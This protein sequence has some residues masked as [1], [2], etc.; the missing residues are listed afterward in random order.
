M[1]RQRGR[2]DD[3]KGGTV[4]GRGAATKLDFGTGS[5]MLSSSYTAGAAAARQGGAATS[6]SYG[7]GTTNGRRL[8]A[9]HASRSRSAA[10]NA[11]HAADEQSGF[12]DTTTAGP[13]ATGAL[14]VNGV[15]APAQACARAR[16]PAVKY[17]G[18]IYM[19]GG[20]GIPDRFNG[21]RLRSDVCFVDTQTCVWHRVVCTGTAFPPPRMHH[22]AGVKDGKLVVHGGISASGEVLN[23]MWALSLRAD[24]H[25]WKRVALYCHADTEPPPL[26]SH[27]AAVTAQVMYFHGGRSS[28]PSHTIY[29]FAFQTQAWDAIESANIGPLL[30]DHCVEVVDGVLYAFGGFTYHQGRHD[31]VNNQLFAYSFE[32]GVWRTISFR[33]RG[34]EN[35]LHDFLTAPLLVR[36]VRQT[37]QLWFAGSSRVYFAALPAG[38]ATCVVFHL[39]SKPSGVPEKRLHSVA[40]AV[41]R[42][43]WLMFGE[44]TGEDPSL[45][46]SSPTAVRRLLAE[47]HATS[48]VCFADVNVYTI[49]ASSWAPAPD[50]AAALN[51]TTAG[52]VAGGDAPALHSSS[53]AR[54]LSPPR[55]RR[56]PQSS[57]RTQVS[58]LARLLK[59]KHD[60]DK[61][62]D[63][64][65]HT[66]I[67]P[68]DIREYNELLGTA[69]DKY[70]A[71]THR[72][73]KEGRKR[74]DIRRARNI[75]SSKAS[76][77]SRGYVLPEEE[78]SPRPSLVAEGV[79]GRAAR[80]AGA[81]KPAA[82]VQAYAR[83]AV[84]AAVVLALRRR[85]HTQ[86]HQAE[87]HQAARKIQAAHRGRTVRKHVKTRR[88]QQAA[89]GHLERHRAATKIQARYRGD[90]ARGQTARLL[91]EARREQEYQRRKRQAAIQIQRVQRG[92]MARAR[93]PSVR[94]P[95]AAPPATMDAVLRV[96]LFGLYR[97]DELVASLLFLARAGK[98]T[99]PPAAPGDG[100]ARARAAA[101][102]QTGVRR[103]RRRAAE[104]FFYWGSTRAV[105]A[106]RLR[107]EAAALRIQRAGRGGGGRADARELEL[108]RQNEAAAAIQRRFRVHGARRVAGARAGGDKARKAAA[109]AA[110]QAAARAKLA[111]LARRRRRGAVRIQ[112]AFRGLRAKREVARQRLRAEAQEALDQDADTTDMDFA[113]RLVQRA[114]RRWKAHRK[115]AAAAG[116][117]RGGLV[118]LAAD[119]LAQEAEYR[120]AAAE[121]LQRGCRRVVAARAAATRR[122]ARQEQRQREAAGAAEQEVA[123]LAAAAGK[124]QRLY[125]QHREAAAAVDEAAERRRRRADDGAA[126]ERAAAA[127]EAGEAAC[128]IQRTV[129]RFK[130]RRRASGARRQ[131][132]AAEEEAQRA[133]QHRAAAASKIQRLYTQHRESTAAVREAAERRRRRADDGAAAE[134]AAAAEEAGEAA[135]FIQRTVRR[136]KARRRASGARRQLT[137]AEEEAQRQHQL[138]A[139]TAAATVQRAYRS[140]CSRRDLTRRQSERA[141]QRATDEVLA[142]AQETAAC[143]GAAETLQRWARCRS[144]RVAA[145]ER[146]DLVAGAE[147]VAVVRREAAAVVQQAY[148]QHA[149]RGALRGKKAERTARRAGEERAAAEQERACAGSLASDVQREARAALSRAKAHAKK[150]GAGPGDAAAAAI[151]KEGSEEASVAT[152]KEGTEAAAVA[153]QKAYRARA[154]RSELQK[155][156]AARAEEEES[157]A[158]A[159]EA[160]ALAFAA[161][162]L[163]RMV[164]GL[165]AR[166]R[167]RAAASEGAPPGATTDI[168]TGTTT[169]TTTKITPGTT[170]GDT[171]DAASEA[172]GKRRH[173]A[174]VD[175]QRAFRGSSARARA[176]AAGAAAAAG[177]PAAA[178]LA[179]RAEA[180]FGAALLQRAGRGG[181]A[182]AEAGLAP[183]ACR[184]ESTAATRIQSFQRMMTAK[185][186]YSKKKSVTFTIERVADEDSTDT[187]AAQHPAVRDDGPDPLAP[188]NADSAARIQRQFRSHRARRAAAGRRA[189]AEAAR[190]ID[191]QLAADDE[192]AAAARIVQHAG[193][194]FS[195]RRELGRGA[196][197]GTAASAA[198]TAE[199]VVAADSPN[200]DGAQHV[201]RNPQAPKD[202][203][204]AARIQRQFRSHRARR[205]ASGMRAAAAAS[206]QVD[207]QLAADGEVATAARIV[208]HVG[209][210]F[211]ARRGM[212]GAKTADNAAQHPMGREDARDSLEPENADSAAQHPINEREDVRDRAPENADNAAQHPMDREDVRDPLAPENADSAACIQRQFRSHRARRA[213]SGRRTT[214]AAA[215][216]ADEQLAAD[217]EAAAAARIVQHAG[218]GFSARRG[219]EPGAGEA[220]GPDGADSADTVSTASTAHEVAAL[221]IQQAHRLAV[222]RRDVAAR[223]AERSQSPAGR[224]P[225]EQERVFAARFVQRVVRGHLA[226]KK[227]RAPVAAG[228][229]PPPAGRQGRRSTLA[230]S[231][232]DDEAATAIQSVVRGAQA[233]ARAAAER[234]KVEAKRRSEEAQAVSHERYRAAALIQSVH[235]GHAARVT[236]RAA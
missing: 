4:N 152:Q 146:R 57:Q 234:D 201:V 212:A 183:R 86:Q 61:M 121:T 29:A 75:D 95:P 131:L 6:S 204:S 27:A 79:A 73:E 30:Y 41:G 119:A 192:A 13:T 214:A 160:Q 134:R 211:S 217:G 108:E 26:A 196:G 71:S 91:E 124:I 179:G 141:S 65:G 176:R 233:R 174:A 227:R 115:A 78:P 184:R 85:A 24:L 223:R 52:A 122:A 197:G 200:T 109:A 159:D 21:G 12:G 125:T 106:Q 209:R 36:C 147:Q 93:Y 53:P 34:A 77:L 150:G 161:I 46:I 172:D 104:R 132:T 226:R 195:A 92:R 203:D 178:A 135:C 143:N 35:G 229:S 19:F 181:L 198:H 219:L 90:L 224:T 103:W 140:S 164:R 44:E 165:L 149:A 16:C 210:G 194:G 17:N 48:R 232:E 84:S 191:E 33:L 236:S 156:S 221:T 114:V 110:L 69:V 137:A 42:T 2:A 216:Q 60:F 162:S 89:E 23:D 97:S 120:R 144:A 222:A 100:W 235:R 218:R 107:R 105:R 64:L 31:A 25:E 177:E 50:A 63:V 117:Q 138:R 225:E 130:A 139:A 67:P 8:V 166:R 58:V 56:R 40:C 199:R 202:A 123:Y 230:R 38:D 54:M 187:D 20:S 15:V 14:K 94:P 55:S 111:L 155:R 82:V 167:K 98:T 126:A 148:R 37:K 9:R 173:A 129:R 220:D 157:L 62:R 190:R 188:K 49:D 171:A 189:A 5:R 151:Q 68:S 83:S 118:A 215:R 170:T 101:A 205:A 145:A 10:R 80:Q 180:E 163:Q 59:E 207:E 127:E 3:V 51:A 39:H 168:T 186:D 182:R 32:T 213:A 116:R 70:L 133:H 45:N 66:S 96:A 228:G 169:G 18:R 87:Q 128:F 175:V 102:I 154:A 142:S 112:C 208:Q 88:E 11:W 1:R 113:A 231:C 158:A 43:L 193:R 22:A 206:R 99:L 74:R 153:I 72:P 76:L 185:R 81:G 47:D 28:S 7:G 136:F